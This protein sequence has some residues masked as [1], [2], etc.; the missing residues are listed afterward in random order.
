MMRRVSMM[1]Y[2]PV[3]ST[4]GSCGRYESSTLINCTMAVKRLTTGRSQL[5]AGSFLL[6]INQPSNGDMP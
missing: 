4:T 1:G 3:A 5:A 6:P 2:G